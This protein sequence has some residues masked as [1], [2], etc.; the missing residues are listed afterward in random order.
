[1]SNRVSSN[2][3]KVCLL[4]QA[5]EDAGKNVEYYA[6]D[7]SERE[8]ERTLAQVPPFKY[9]SCRGLLGTF[10]DGREWLKQPDVLGKP[11][12][13]LYMGSSIGTYRTRR[14]V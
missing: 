11:K 8:L 13:V 2:L 14:S 7:V 12:C 9:V 5:L 4:L 10:E 1:M 6:L 3:R